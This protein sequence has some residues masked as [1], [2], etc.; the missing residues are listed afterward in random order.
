MIRSMGRSAAG[1]ALATALTLAPQTTAAAHGPPP[2][3]WGGATCATASLDGVHP[4]DG[5]VL[6]GQ[7]TR[8][9]DN[10]SAEASFAIVYFQNDT[11]YVWTDR[12]RPYN[13]MGEPRPFGVR[14]PGRAS[15]IRGVCVMSNP[16]TRLA[17]G[18][19][20]PTRTGWRFDR[21]PTTDP[22]VTAPVAATATREFPDGISDPDCGSCF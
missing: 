3:P 13:P 15:K 19:I 1:L 12:L 18:S 8:C 10:N 22:L 17:C 21:I 11:S 7:A 9:D 5:S 4:R 14:T 16:D 2:I 6:L 20:T